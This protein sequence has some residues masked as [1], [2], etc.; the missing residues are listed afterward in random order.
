MRICQ[1]KWWSDEL[2]N[3]HSRQEPT[4]T[5]TQQNVWLNRQE[6]IPTWVQQNVWLN[7]QEPTPTWVQQNVWLNRQQPTTTCI[8]QNVWLTFNCGKYYFR[9][10][11][12]K[13]IHL[14][15]FFVLILNKYVYKCDLAYRK[16]PCLY[17][18]KAIVILMNRKSM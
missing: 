2:Y 16:L 18:W 9:L 7:R 15:G 10:G 14:L 1:C 6:P 4:P 3:T 11:I 17:V 13:D 5:C 8:Q 12:Y